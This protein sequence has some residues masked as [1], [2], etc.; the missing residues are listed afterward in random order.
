M[1]GTYVEDNTTRPCAMSGTDV[2]NNTTRPAD[3]YGGAHGFGAGARLAPKKWRR[4]VQGLS[5][6]AM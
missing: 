4:R 2:E 6:Y 1:P 5:A 3:H